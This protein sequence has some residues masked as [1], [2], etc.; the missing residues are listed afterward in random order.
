MKT[1]VKLALGALM[2]ATAMAAQAQVDIAYHGPLVA[3][4]RFLVFVDASLVAGYLLMAILVSGAFLA[5]SPGFPC[6]NSLPLPK[7]KRHPLATR[8][9]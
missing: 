7:G 9:R 2:F 4:F 8:A 6:S 3:G 5:D 1:L